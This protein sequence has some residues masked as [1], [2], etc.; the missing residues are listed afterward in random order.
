MNYYNEQ[1]GKIALAWATENIRTGGKMPR[2]FVIEK[3][4]NGVALS[5]APLAV[6][7]A[8]TETTILRAMTGATEALGQVT[9]EVAWRKMAQL[10]SSDAI[11]YPNRVALIRR[12]NP[13]LQEQELTR[14]LNRFQELVALDTIRN[15]YLMHAKLYTW[16]MR[17]PARNNLRKLNEKVYASLFLTPSSDPWLG[18][19]AT[20][21][22]TALDNSGLLKP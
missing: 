16:F 4:A 21:I 1:H 5:L 17:D 3:D 11:L 6:T 20:D 15:E 2:G 7:K 13:T 18:L 9:D 22:Y 12:Q 14:L 8:A 19:F 10:H